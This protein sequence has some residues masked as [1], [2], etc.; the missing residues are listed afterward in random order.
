[1]TALLTGEVPKGVPWPQDRIIPKSEWRPP[2]G[3][4]IVSADDHVMEPPNLWTDRMPAPLQSSAP[5]L[6]KDASGYHMEVEGRSFDKPGFNSQLIEGREGIEDQAARLL[7]MDKA[8]VDISIV[9]PQRAMALFVIEK[10]R[11]LTAAADVYNEWLAEWS[12]AAPDRLVGVAILPT[13]HEPEQAS[14]YVKK[15]SRLGFKAVMLPS[16]PKGVRYNSSAMEPIWQAI[17]DNDLT[18]CF[19][20][21]EFGFSSGK[22][23]LLTYITKQ[24]Q[25]FRELW[26]LLTYSGVFERH[27]SLRV[28]FTEGGAGWA[29][30]AAYEAD[31]VYEKYIT[32]AHPKL[33]HLP[34]FYW[35]RNCSATIMDDPLA[36]REASRIG[37]ENILW[38]TDYP[39]PEGIL[40]EEMHVLK[41]I[42]DDLGE[43]AGRLIAGENAVRIF[44]IE[45]KARERLLSR[46]A[47]GVK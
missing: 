8:N 33:T 20:I 30:S 34:S 32:E 17:A 38:S 35:R 22:G 11:E 39:H 36:I 4:V 24:L 23:A 40:G 10:Q 21:G 6:W 7:D 2:V 28:V 45:E 9:F 18:L 41:Q 5:R 13:I 12:S 31:R 15:L 14:S 27:P 25:S 47:T 16:Y 29:A 44:K 26:A 43:K 1:M 42:Y 19:H 46:G 3:D 37:A